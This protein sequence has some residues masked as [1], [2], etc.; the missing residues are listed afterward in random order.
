MWSAGGLLTA[1]VLF[2][3]KN[4]PRIFFY[5]VIGA[6]SFWGILLFVVTPP[7]F[8]TEFWHSLAD[9]FI[10]AAIL[11]MT[12]DQYIKERILHE[13]TSDISKYLIGYRLPEQ[14]QD[15]LRSIMQ[16][17]W[18][19]RT[20]EVR[21][22]F[23]EMAAEETELDITVS[24]QVQNITSETQEYI[25]TVS[26]SKFERFQVVE[27]R[28]DNQNTT[29]HLAGKQVKPVEESGQ[30]R[31]RGNLVKIPPT[32]DSPEEFRFSVR[33][34]T[35]HPSSSRKTITFR[36]ATIGAVIEMTDCPDSYVFHLSPI[37]DITAHNR[38]TYN[39]LFLPGE[40]ISIQWERTQPTGPNWQKKPEVAL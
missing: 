10:V 31:H 36:H 19:R 39:R 17:T 2:I 33:Y 14:V 26:F 23:S 9:A 38:W 22:R 11:A 18:I 24:S 7:I 5:S 34:K 16:T 29:Y 3:L 28:C 35:G 8:S 12:V 13:V 6:A 25:D 15:R 37:P 40:Q 27:L 20:F 32:S 21:V 30:I 1:V 4:K